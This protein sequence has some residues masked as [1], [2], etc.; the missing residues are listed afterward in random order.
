MLT[1]GVII[2][3]AGRGRL[4]CVRICTRGDRGAPERDVHA[5]MS[6]CGSPVPKTSLHWT[7]AHR[8]MDGNS[9]HGEEGRAHAGR[10]GRERLRA[11]DATAE[12]SG[13]GRAPGEQLSI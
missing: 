11:S 2:R 10:P 7:G 6:G 9:I 3:K 12:H 8:P 5:R 13:E 4:Q 1:E